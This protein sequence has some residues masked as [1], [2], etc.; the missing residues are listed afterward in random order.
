[1]GAQTVTF[2]QFVGIEL[3]E[4]TME[5]LAVTVVKASFAEAFVKITLIR[6]GN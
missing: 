6:A 5:R 4:S 1:M 2:A 3:R